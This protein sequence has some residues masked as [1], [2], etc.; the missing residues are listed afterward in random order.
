MLHDPQEKLEKFRI[1]VDMVFEGSCNH[2]IFVGCALTWF[3][4]L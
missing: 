4:I 2:S 3:V 1:V